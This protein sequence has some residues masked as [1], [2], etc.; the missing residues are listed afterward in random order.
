MPCDAK[1]IREV[2]PCRLKRQK[3]GFGHL[4]Q[5]IVSQQLSKAAADSIMKRLVALAG[6]RHLTAESFQAVSDKALKSASFPPA[7]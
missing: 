1:I 4:A 6:N 7:R 3:G 5:A 2:G